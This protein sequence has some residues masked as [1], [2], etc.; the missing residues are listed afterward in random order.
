M[1]AIWQLFG[2]N[3]ANQ[4]TRKHKP[5]T[6]PSLL[7]V[8]ARDILLQP[9]AFHAYSAFHVVQNVLYRALIGFPQYPYSTYGTLLC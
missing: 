6:I 3:S 1:D 7:Q 5:I 9:I 8:A 2:V 4:L